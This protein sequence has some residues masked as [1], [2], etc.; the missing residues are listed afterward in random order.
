MY[1]E[2]RYKK[3]LAAG[4]DLKNRG[5]DYGKNGLVK[6]FLSR[7]MFMNNTMSEFLLK[8]DNWL[9]ET[10][11]SVKKIQFLKNFTVDKNDRS[12]NI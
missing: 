1:T 12:L 2:S 6:K 8:F 7:R 10:T 3:V 4:S 5:Y 9:I 11:E